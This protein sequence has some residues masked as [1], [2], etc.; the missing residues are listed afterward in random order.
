MNIATL[1]YNTKNAQFGITTTPGRQSIQ[2]PQAT[3]DIRQPKAAMNISSTPGVLAIDQSQAWADMDRKHIFQRI[4]EA[5][6]EG[7]Q[8]AIEGTG[9]RAMEGRELA[10]IHKGGNAIVAQ[11]ARHSMRNYETGLTWIPSHG[12]VKINYQPGDVNIDVQARKVENNTR[13]NKPVISY[14]PGDV[15]FQLKQYPSIDFQVV[16]KTI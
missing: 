15:S 3:V 2:Q 6:A 13:A 4:R 14:Q 5:A 12:S 1:Q 16:N 10:D 9:R 7:R 8:K 11:A